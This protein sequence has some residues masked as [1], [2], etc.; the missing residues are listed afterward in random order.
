MGR[1]DDLLELLEVDGE[2]NVL[3]VSKAVLQ[4]LHLQRMQQLAVAEMVDQLLELLQSLNLFRRNLLFHA[5]PEQLHIALHI[6]YSGLRKLYHMQVTSLNLRNKHHKKEH[7]HQ[8]RLLL[9]PRDSCQD[10]I[11]RLESSFKIKSHMVLHHD[12][13]KTNPQLAA[14]RRCATNYDC[15][16]QK[17]LP[18]ENR[19][20]VQNNSKSGFD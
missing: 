19:S 14:K 2:L 18:P 9:H 4:L 10:K 13:C 7:H 17:P 8:R 12:K 3:A 15:S 11:D 16:P 5:L 1:T 20:A 6:I